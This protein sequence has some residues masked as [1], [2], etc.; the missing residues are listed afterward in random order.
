MNIKEKEVKI[1]ACNQNIYLHS[2]TQIQTRII[3]HTKLLFI[4][5]F[6]FLFKDLTNFVSFFHKYAY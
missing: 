1:R 3:L 5:Y 6:S 2:H 4:L